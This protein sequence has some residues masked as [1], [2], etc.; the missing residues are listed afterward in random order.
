MK[1]SFDL[2]KIHI[3][4]FLSNCTMRNKIQ[5]DKKQ[6]GIYTLRLRYIRNEILHHKPLK[7]MPYD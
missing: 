1:G 4:N 3:K 7:E 5:E 2:L 6:T